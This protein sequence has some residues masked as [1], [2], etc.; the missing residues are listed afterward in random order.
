MSIRL[1][2]GVAAM[3]VC[4]GAA[5]GCGSISAAAPDGGTDVPSGAD[6][7]DVPFGVDVINEDFPAER[8]AD[9][10]VDAGAEAGI[11]ADTRACTVKIN[12][13][14]TGGTSALDEFIELYNTCPDQP[15]D[16]TGYTLVYRSAAG[17]ADSIRVSFTGGGFTVGKA[18][19]VCANSAYVGPADAHYTE[20]LNDAGGGLAIRAP[21]GH[22]V[23]SVGATIAVTSAARAAVAVDTTVAR[24]R[25][26][27]SR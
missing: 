11:D 24:H 6:V 16:L 19:I 12:E 7:S 3:V 27:S 5:A 22:V 13:L 20:G 21:D 26:V 25:L 1:R 15:L 4:A 2:F 23:D 10:R 17:T 18:F 9:V 14:Q 8:N